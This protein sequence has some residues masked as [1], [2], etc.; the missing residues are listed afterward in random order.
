MQTKQN[1]QTN[2]WTYLWKLWIKLI[3]YQID[4]LNT[5][6]MNDCWKFKK[7]INILNFKKY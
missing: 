1:K 5:Y 4:Y 7:K 2:K 6:T 3:P